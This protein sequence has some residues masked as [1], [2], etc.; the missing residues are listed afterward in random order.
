MEIV[1]LHLH[2][3]ENFAWAKFACFFCKLRKIY[4]E[5]I[6]KHSSISQ[7]FTTRIVPTGLIR[8]HEI[9]AH[10]LRI[11]LTYKYHGFTILWD[12]RGIAM[13]FSSDHCAAVRRIIDRCRRILQIANPCFAKRSR[14]LIIRIFNT[15]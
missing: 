5:V 13:W 11:H 6:C 12:C 9:Y 7:Y 4:D 14:L 3:F 10:H 1:V 8:P 15:L 2:L